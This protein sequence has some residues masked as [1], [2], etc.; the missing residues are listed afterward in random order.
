VS[1]FATKEF[2][3]FARKA[4]LAARPLL[5]AAQEV[6]AGHFDADLGGGVSSSASHATGEASQA[7]FAR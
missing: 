1:V 7:A 3:R 2:S 5:K 4:G 6:P